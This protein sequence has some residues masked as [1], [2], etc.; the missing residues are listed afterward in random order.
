MRLFGPNVEHPQ[1][2]ILTFHSS[3]LSKQMSFLFIPVFFQNRMSQFETEIAGEV[4][5]NSIVGMNSDD[6][7]LEAEFIRNP[8]KDLHLR[9]NSCK[10]TH[11]PCP[12]ASLCA[13]SPDA[14]AEIGQ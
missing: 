4:I 3:F 1:R 11:V 7:D 5:C 2:V 8:I 12:N 14:P 9:S 13:D 10:G 6:R